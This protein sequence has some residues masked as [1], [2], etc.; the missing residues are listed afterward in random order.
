MSGLRTGQIAMEIEN[1]HNT[2]LRIVY[3]RKYEQDAEHDVAIK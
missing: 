2:I 3:N 1:F